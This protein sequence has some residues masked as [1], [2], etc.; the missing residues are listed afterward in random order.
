MITDG[1]NPLNF[2][3]LLGTVAASLGATALWVYARLSGRTTAARRILQAEVGG[4]AVY[5]IALLSSSILSHDRV[6][7]AGQEKHICEIDCHTS[8]AVS[9]VDTAHSLGQATA[10]G[11]FYVVTLRVRFDSNTISSRRGMGPLTPN[12]RVLRVIA[13]DGTEYQPSA[14][15]EAALAALEGPPIPLTKPVIPGETYLTKVVFDLPATVAEPRLLLLAATGLP[16]R[17]VIGYENSL[18]HAKTA[19]RLAV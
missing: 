1:L 12:G 6:L 19:F 16:D 11:I 17:L 18:L 14:D 10:H 4:L 8:Y 5:A 13:G 15:G 3:L 9:D 7:A 2:L